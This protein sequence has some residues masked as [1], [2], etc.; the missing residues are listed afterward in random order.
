MKLAQFLMDIYERLYGTYGPQYWWPATTKFEIVLGAILT[1]NTAWENVKR[2]LENLRGANCVTPLAI[3]EISVERLSLLIRPSGYFNSKAKKLKAFADY[4][5]LY[6]DEIGSWSTRDPKEL[7]SELLKLYGLRPETADDIVLYVAELPSFVIDT[8]TR[9][10]IGRLGIEPISDTYDSYQSLFEDNLPHQSRLYNE[11]HA[12]LD[13]HAKVTC[14][15]RKPI[16]TQCCLRDLCV[17]GK[18]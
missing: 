18:S 14:M 11:Y 2:A 13:F 4:L 5:A 9:R 12:L 3:R 15:K 17:T 16:C 6:N 1:Q 8:Y 7:R 10:I